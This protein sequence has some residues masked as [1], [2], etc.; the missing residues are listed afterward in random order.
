MRTGAVENEALGSSYSKCFTNE[1]VPYTSTVLGFEHDIPVY[2]HT[3]RSFQRTSASNFIA[4]KLE[5]GFAAV[6]SLATVTQTLTARRRNA[7]EACARVGYALAL[8]AAHRPTGL[9][10]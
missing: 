8:V 10:P 1:T 5:P 7:I 4:F 2:H 9:T 3:S 6:T